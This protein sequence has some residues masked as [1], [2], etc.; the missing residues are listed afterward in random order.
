MCKD[1]I[2]FQ[3]EIEGLPGTVEQAAACERCGHFRFARNGKTRRG[4][5]N[6]KCK[7]CGRQSDLNP[8]NRVIPAAV[9]QVAARLLAAGVGVAVVHQA[10]GISKSSLYTIKNKLVGGNSAQGV[11]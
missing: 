10:T 9:K 6:F 7:A 11:C 5:K 1:I 4:S 2:T 8:E 3:V